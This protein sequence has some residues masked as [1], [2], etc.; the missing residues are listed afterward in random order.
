MEFVF[1][2]EKG[3]ILTKVF[4]KDIFYLESQRDYVAVHTLEKRYMV[5][6]I[7]TDVAE[8]MP[9]GRFLRI[10]RSYMVQPS[11]VDRVEESSLFINGKRLSIGEKFRKEFKSKIN[12]L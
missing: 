7:L 11:L 9:K 10:H 3:G 5:H 8:K 1:I 2:K 12:L 4:V 6:D